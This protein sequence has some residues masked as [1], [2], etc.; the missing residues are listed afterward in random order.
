MVTD[1]ELIFIFSQ[2]LDQR[3]GKSVHSHFTHEDTEAQRDYF[4]QII[5]HMSVAEIFLAPNPVLFS[6]YFAFGTYVN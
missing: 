6:L 2:R 5:R 3:M 1:K 4:A